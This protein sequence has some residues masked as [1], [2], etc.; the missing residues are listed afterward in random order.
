MKNFDPD[1]TYI[2]RAESD[3]TV[4]Q[5]VDPDATII[6]NIDPGATI[7]RAD[8][9]PRKRRTT[10]LSG[11]NTAAPTISPEVAGL[12]EHRTHTVR[13]GTQALEAYV[14]QEQA[15]AAPPAPAPAPVQ[16][17]PQAQPAAAV[18][19]PAQVKPQAKPAAAKKTFWQTLQQPFQALRRK[20]VPVLTQMSMVECGA[21]S[22]AMILS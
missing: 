9:L 18:Q 22:L 6:Q 19:A 17:P 10:L 3:A 15:Q 16:A 8:F 2:Q 4:I 7:L 5:R 21:A 1:A 12:I 14:A 11:V 13:L 20:R